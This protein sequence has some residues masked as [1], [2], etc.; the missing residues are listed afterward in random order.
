MRG[1]SLPD[2]ALEV[3]LARWAV[4]QPSENLEALLAEVFPTQDAQA[5]Q[6]ALMLALD[7]LGAADSEAEGMYAVR[8]ANSSAIHAQLINA[9]PMFS[10]FGV[11]RAVDRALFN[12]R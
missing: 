1:L 5:I 8:F 12:H 10:E 4:A 6:S 7:L 3:R 2:G 9:F 11:S